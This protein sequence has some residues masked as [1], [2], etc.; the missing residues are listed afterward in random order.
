M[1]IAIRPHNEEAYRRIVKGL[2]KDNI[3]AVVYP[4]LSNLVE[5]GIKFLGTTNGKT[6]CVEGDSRR[7]HGGIK[8]SIKYLEE[9]GKIDS[10]LME[11]YKKIDYTTYSRLLTMVKEE[12]NLEGYEN[13]LLLDLE[14]SGDLEWEKGID[15]L[16]GKNKNANT[17]GLVEFSSI[18]EKSCN[19]TLRRVK[20]HIVSFM[21]IEEGTE[22]GICFPIF[23]NDIDATNN[24]LKVLL[25]KINKLEDRNLKEK[26]KEKVVEAKSLNKQVDELTPRPKGELEDIFQMF[27]KE[28]EEDDVLPEE[29]V[30]KNIKL[31]LKV[32]E[33]RNRLRKIMDEIRQELG[34]DIEVSELEE[35]KR[36][37]EGLGK[38]EEEARNLLEQAQEISEQEEKIKEDE[39]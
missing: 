13:I 6:I 19:P 8:S 25:R 23:T 5:V 4:I 14:N 20:N 1:D 26:L 17:V 32:L 11:R 15:V 38:K 28:D 29:E 31:D 3:V 18:G 35:I 24:K 33:L 7:S 9:D 21:S 34:E 22:L 30:R 39:R 10:K 37:H 16:L 12:K 36:E 2:E 27:E